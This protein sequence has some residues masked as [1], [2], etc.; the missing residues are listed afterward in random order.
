MPSTP[1]FLLASCLDITMHSTLKPVS[2]ETFHFI[3]LFMFNYPV[4]LVGYSGFWFLYIPIWWSIMRIRYLTCIVS[5]TLSWAETIAFIVTH[6]SFDPFGKRKGW[7]LEA[8][9]D[10]A[11]ISDTIILAFG[12]LL[13]DGLKGWQ[14]WGFLFSFIRDSLVAL[15]LCSSFM[16]GTEDW[17]M[18]LYIGDSPVQ[19]LQFEDLLNFLTYRRHGMWIPST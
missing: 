11:Y 13:T 18:I 5:N 17:Y 2:K 6:H 8:W 7:K 15:R 4:Q 16:L 9:A 1:P 10:L 19:S 14:S 3:F 12:L